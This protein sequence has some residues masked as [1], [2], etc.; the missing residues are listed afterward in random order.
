MNACGN[1]PKYWLTRWLPVSGN[2]A[3][4]EYSSKIT[5]QSTQHNP[6]IKMPLNISPEMCAIPVSSI[7]RKIKDLNLSNERCTDFWVPIVGPI[8]FSIVNLDSCFLVLHTN[9]YPTAQFRNNICKVTQFWII[10][11]LSEVAQGV[12]YSNGL[13]LTLIYSL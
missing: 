5:I 3:A 1:I 6:S 12:P 11:Y 4:E 9:K 2:L 7:P 8:F 13:S 10:W